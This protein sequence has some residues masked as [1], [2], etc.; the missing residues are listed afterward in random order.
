MFRVRCT[1]ADRQF[2]SR[3]HARVDCV[4]EASHWLKDVN[5]PG[6]ISSPPEA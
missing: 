1:V 5:C 6:N 2:S 3:H 4:N